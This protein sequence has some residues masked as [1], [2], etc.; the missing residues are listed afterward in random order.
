MIIIMK[1]LCVLLYK[2]VSV[3]SVEG[4]GQMCVHVIYVHIINCN[5]MDCTTT[6]KDK[7]VLDKIIC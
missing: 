4:I 2:Q 6:S 1:E 7:M 3:G 5:G